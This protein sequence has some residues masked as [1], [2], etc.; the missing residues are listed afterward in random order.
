MLKESTLSGGMKGVA[1]RQVSHFR[2]SSEARLLE[3]DDVE[4]YRFIFERLRQISV[5][6]LKKVIKS[7]KE[8]RASG[9]LEI[10][11]VEI[12]NKLR[13][14]ASKSGDRSLEQRI[15]R[16]STEWSMRA[17]EVGGK[18]LGHIALDLRSLAEELGNDDA[19][20]MQPLRDLR[21]N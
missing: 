16:L 13:D 18:D 8:N 5:A 4:L 21:P 17:L 2:N 12:L 20:Q 6:V 19:P 15:E 10:N 11:S 7:L 9:G 1:K 3:N 14:I